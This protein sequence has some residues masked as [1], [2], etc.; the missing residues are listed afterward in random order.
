LCYWKKRN[1]IIAAA[2]AERMVV[3][4]VA[5]EDK[6]E[7]LLHSLKLSDESLTTVNFHSLAYVTE[8]I[9]Q[10]DC[11]MFPSSV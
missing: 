11:K 1:N 4:A 5:A 9:R 7:E 8:L 6:E 10:R 2:A 3:V